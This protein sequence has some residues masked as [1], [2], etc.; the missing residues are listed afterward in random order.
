[1]F[2][3]IV[4]ILE[5]LFKLVVGL[6]GLSFTSFSKKKG[7]SADFGSEGNLLSRW[8][9]GFS[10]TGR[11]QITVK[12]SFM[13]CLVTGS[14]G[15]GKSQ[16]TIF[17]TTFCAEGSFVIYDPGELY[18]KTAGYLKG[19]RGYDIKVLNFSKPEMSACFNP[20]SR[21]NTSSEIQRLAAMLVRTSLSGGKED[22]FWTTQATALLAVLIAILKTQPA[23]YQNLFNVRLLLNQLNTK[24]D[25]D[26]ASNPVDDLFAQ[27]AD[28]VLFSEYRSIIALDSKL[29]S[30]ICATCKSALTIFA[31]QAVARIT[32]HDS[33]DFADL[34]NRRTAIFLRIDITDQ[35]Y[36]RA[37]LAIFFE[38]L[39]SYALSRFP[40]ENE[41]NI[42]LLLEEFGSIA[43]VPSFPAFFANCRKHSVG[44]LAIVQSHMQIVST[45]GKED[46]EAI[47]ANCFSKLHFGGGGAEAT[48]ELEQ[49]LG[50]YDYIDEKGKKQTRPLLTNDEIRMLKPNRALLIC[51]HHAPILAR[52]HPAYKSR[53]Y[54]EYMAVKPPIPQGDAPAAVS[55]LQL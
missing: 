33:I 18:L 2:E 41:Q 43:R 24:I 44:V 39:S 42:F 51:G 10:L 49:I 13:N 46:A 20:M 21:A 5:G 19:H 15:T 40:E 26:D 45:Y 35:S 1:M 55:V 36:F 34:R 50:K 7:Y 48:R 29:L 28:P 17:K 8:N 12:N 3:L 9:K 31:D 30:S 52:M 37:L 6:V 22:P 16:C 25:D 47:R 32:S 38:Q 4:S 23:E 54:R 11:K 27:Y 53:R 14:T